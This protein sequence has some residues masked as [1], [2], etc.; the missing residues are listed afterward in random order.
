[1]KIALFYNG[2][3]I[4]SELLGSD[5]F[6]VL[7]GRYSG[8]SIYRRVRQHVNTILQPLGKVAKYYRIGTGERLGH[9]IDSARKSPYHNI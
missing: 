3:T 7:D 4:D 9:C 1:M 8:A 6:C 5:C 2:T